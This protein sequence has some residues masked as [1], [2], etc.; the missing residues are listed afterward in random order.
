MKRH[1]LPLVAVISSAAPAQDQGITWYLTPSHGGEYPLA[2]RIN[3]SLLAAGLDTSALLGAL[4]RV[5][6]DHRP[7]A[8]VRRRLPTEASYPEARVTLTYSDTLGV[9]ATAELV[10]AAPGVAVARARHGRP[11]LVYTQLVD[12]GPVVR[13]RVSD[14]VK[15]TLK[16]TCLPG[17]TAPRAFSPGTPLRAVDSGAVPGRALPTRARDRGAGPV[18]RIVV[19]PDTVVMRV[20]EMKPIFLLMKRAGY[21]A[22]GDS[23]RFTPWYTFVD[24]AVARF[25]DGQVE[26][27]SVGVARV[28]MGEMVQVPRLQRSRTLRTFWIRV[29]AP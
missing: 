19:T 22:T 24:E 16:T 11:H 4:A 15:Q 21:T 10:C 27:L 23:V 1:W 5:A 18:A 8:E 14:M 2:L 29:M 25:R 6:Q 28:E 3:R 12:W 20:G 17:E 13:L 7:F 9:E 26:A